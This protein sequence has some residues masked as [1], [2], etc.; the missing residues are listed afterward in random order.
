MEKGF[1][2]KQQFVLQK[3]SMAPVQRTIRDLLAP[4]KSS[5]PRLEAAGDRFQRPR[6]FHVF[7]LE[8]FRVV[9]F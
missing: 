1:H 5:D 2:V 4:E 6:I 9:G 3:I 8:G 7:G